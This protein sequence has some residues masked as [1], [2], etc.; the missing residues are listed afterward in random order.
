MHV[1]IDNKAVVD[2]ANSLLDLASHLCKQRDDEEVIRSNACITFDIA[3]KLNKPERLHWRMQ[4][5][6]DVW[7]AIWR[8]IL[9]KG[10]HAI[11]VSKVKGHATEQHVRDGTAT[12]ATK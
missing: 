2:R 4:K 9:A 11:K 3:R 1:G 8:A 5:D 10:P 12:A 6:G 7:Q